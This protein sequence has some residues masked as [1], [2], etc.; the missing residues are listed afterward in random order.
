M[1]QDWAKA[2]DTAGAQGLD[3]RKRLSERGIPP[4]GGRIGDVGRDFNKE[5]KTRAEL[6]AGYASVQDGSVETE[7]ASHA[8]G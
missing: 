2:D 4:W 7:S 3:E 5:G 1:A 8:T 6:L